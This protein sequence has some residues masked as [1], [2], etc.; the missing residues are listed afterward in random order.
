[1]R[2]ALAFLLATWL[3]L[4]MPAAALKIGAG[5]GNTVFVDTRGNADRPIAVWYHRPAAFTPDSPV[6][7]VM[8]GLGR[9]GRTYRDAWVSLV[10]APGA[11]LIVPEFSQAAYPG[12]GWYNFGNMFDAKGQANLIERWSYLAIEHL[13]DAVRQSTGARRPTYLLYG[14]SAGGQYVHRVVTFVPELRAARVIAA[15]P[16]WYTLPLAD[17]DF[18]H[19]LKGTTVTNPDL[20]RAF[21]RPLILLLGEADTQTDDPDLNVEP[22]TMKQGPHRFARGT[23]YYAL[24]QTTAAGLG[25]PFAWT[26]RTVP[27]VGHSNAK[28][29]PAAARL[30]FE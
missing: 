17:T 9:S 20:A 23:H 11:L 30:L 15:N 21:A 3:G 8:H 12:N 2:G 24:A 4:A 22:A 1:M 5:S 25:V 28:M 29:A 19:G 16:G 26:K 27:G 7:F 13:F 14:H 18:P 6:L 10:E